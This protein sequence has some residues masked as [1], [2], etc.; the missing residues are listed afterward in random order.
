MFREQKARGLR[1]SLEPGGCKMKWAFR[2]EASK[3]EDPPH[4]AG[5]GEA[6]TLLFGRS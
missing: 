2:N 1:S 6:S 5:P 3:P 4:F